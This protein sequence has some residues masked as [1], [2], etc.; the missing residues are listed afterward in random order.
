MGLILILF[1]FQEWLPQRQQS[2]QCKKKNTVKANQ[3]C[4]QGKSMQSG[5]LD[6]AE[7]RNSVF[8]YKHE[9]F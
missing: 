1:A 2:P 4:H 5:T 8:M 9:A 7:Q 6:E 3:N